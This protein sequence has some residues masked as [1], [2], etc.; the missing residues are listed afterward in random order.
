MTTQVIYDLKGM[1]DSGLSML[2]TFDDVLY[3]IGPDTSLEEAFDEA[4]RVVFYD[5]I[6]ADGQVDPSEVELFNIVFEENYSPDTFRRLEGGYDYEEAADNVFQVLQGIGRV[7]KTLNDSPDLDIEA[8]GLTCSL[9]NGVENLA[10]VLIRIDGHIDANEKRRL[11]EIIGRC[12]SMLK[13]EGLPEA[14]ME[15][16]YFEEIEEGDGASEN[17]PPTLSS[18]ADSSVDKLQY[19]TECAT[20]VQNQGV[21]L[22]RETEELSN[23]VF[24]QA[25][26]LKACIR[27]IGDLNNDILHNLKRILE[28]LQGAEQLQVIHDEEM[29]ETLYSRSNKR[30]AEDLREGLADLYAFLEHVKADA[31]E[32]NAKTQREV[33]GLHARNSVAEIHSAADEMLSALED[34]AEVWNVDLTEIDPQTHLRDSTRLYSGQTADSPAF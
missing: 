17:T 33:G 12:R 20:R 14:P 4:A 23:S 31:K 1:Y 3:G 15:R 22:D 24:K 2:R 11:E 5:L 8:Q 13:A 28:N 27:S 19:V 30:H 34:V 18:R 7:E 25:I 6:F 26:R 32:L 10:Q 9:V 21:N 29:I 16:T